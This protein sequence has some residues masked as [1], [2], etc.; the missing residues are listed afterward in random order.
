MAGMV[1]SGRN[2][3]A[4]AR[5]GSP[6]ALTLQLSQLIVGKWIVELDAAGILVAPHDRGKGVL[7]SNGYQDLTA[8][9]R[10]IPAVEHRSQRGEIGNEYRSRPLNRHCRSGQ[11]D[12]LA[13]TTTTTAKAVNSPSK[14]QHRKTPD[15]HPVMLCQPLRTG[16]CFDP[17]CTMTG[18]NPRSL[19]SSGS[20][21]EGGRPRRQQPCSPV[22]SFVL[23]RACTPFAQWRL[24]AQRR[25]R[26][27]RRGRNR[28]KPATVP[29]LN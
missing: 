8:V 16:K 4:D 11:D 7:R 17:H 29:R 6:A 24:R 25:R 18:H 3:S 23:A 22:D 13:H 28:R 19:R 21:P 26:Y 5:D 12:R 1:E 27:R 15:C 10:Q 2:G 14:L 9:F 20:E